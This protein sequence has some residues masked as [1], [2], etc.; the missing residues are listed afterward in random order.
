MANE[1]QQAAS[2]LSLERATKALKRKMDSMQ[3]PTYDENTQMIVFPATSKYRYD[4]NTQMIV[5]S[6]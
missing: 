4:E 6:E 1:A 5:M 3:A 2:V